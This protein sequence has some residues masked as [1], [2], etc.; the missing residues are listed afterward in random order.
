MSAARGS[1][2]AIV[3][4]AECDLGVTDSS[5]LTLQSQAV[6][7][8][9]ADA[10][11]TLA[12]VDGIATTGV[13]RFSAT[14]LADYF[15]IVPTWTDSTFAGGSAFEMF[16]ARAAQAIE[17]G[18]A[19]VVVISFASNQRSARSRKLGGVHE[20]W[21]PE[22]QFEE[23]YDMLYPLSYYAMAAQ[24]Y[25]HRYGGTREQLAEVAI[26]AREWALLNPKAFR[27]G[28][29]SLSV[30]DVLGSTMISSPLTA[31]DCCLVTDGGGAIVL[32]SLERARDLKQAPVQ[33]LGYGERTTNTSFTAVA[34]LSVPGAR[35]A[36]QD[37]Y[38]RAGITAADVDVAEVYDSF[39]ITAALSVEALGLCGEG[40]ALDFIADGR[41]R[42]GGSHPLNTNGGGLSYCHPGQYGVLLLVE[43]VRQLRGECGARQVPGAEIAVAHGTGGILSTHATVVLG[44]SR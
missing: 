36:V 15:G 11:L 38:A 12:D 1:G 28:K 31:A 42:P 32:T 2:V 39:T 17:A 14:Q 6:T 35:G 4:A 26:A 24:S 18:Q 34:D 30:S 23:P 21:I 37:A 7:R 5:I 22:A 41:I 40:E 20:P 3:G 8:A 13:S 43:A 19:S 29:G 27:H 10:G 25:L 16:V 44:G 9:L 33:V